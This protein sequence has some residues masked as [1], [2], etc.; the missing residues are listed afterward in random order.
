MD[1]KNVST[2]ALVEELASR[3]A[4]EKITVEPYEPYSI[5][6][7]EH[8]ISDGGPVVILRIWD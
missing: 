8:K 6:V 4:V 2:K 3:E 1:L 5:T 7:G